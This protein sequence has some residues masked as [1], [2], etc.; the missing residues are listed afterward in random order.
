MLPETVKKYYV[1]Q[2]NKVLETYNSQAPATCYA[3]IR[4]GLKD[5][6]VIEVEYEMSDWQVVRKV[7]EGVVRALTD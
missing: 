2:G 7:S 1:V 4:D 6:E 5:L 3:K